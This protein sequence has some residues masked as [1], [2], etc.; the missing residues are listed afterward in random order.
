MKKFE[1]VKRPAIGIEQSSIK[2]SLGKVIEFYTDK[3]KE[4]HNAFNEMNKYID[5]LEA[6]LDYYK[7]DKRFEVMAEEILSLKS[8]LKKQ[9]PEI[10]EFV[11]NYIEAAK[12]DFWTLLSAMDDPNL[13]SRVGDWL[14]G[15]NFNNQEIFA[16]AW[17]NGYTVAKE[18]QFYLKH[19]SVLIFDPDSDDSDVEE[20]Y[21]GAGGNFVPY[22]HLAYKFTQ[23][24]I[25]SMET[26]SYEK[27]E[28][29][30]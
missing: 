23:Q 15:G 28:V 1:E 4:Y 24:E 2:P 7:K 30:E 26:G 8:Q 19:K 3:V 21:L 20:L 14:K 18:K 5:G 9:Q 22:Q 16:Q 17:I 29:E 11:A 12:E 6:Q 13:S 25:D 27:I 10:P